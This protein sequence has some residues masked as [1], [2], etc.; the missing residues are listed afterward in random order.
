MLILGLTGGIAMG[1]SHVARLFRGHGV[2]LFDSDAAVHALYAPGGR[3]AR[4]VGPA[5]PGSADESGG[6]DRG[7]L[8]ALVIG[9]Q[10]KLRVLERIVHGLVREEQVAF[11]RLACAQGRL[12]VVLDVPLLLET[13]LQRRVDRV[14]VVSSPALLQRDRALCRP[15]MTPARLEAIRAQQMPDGIKRRH[16]DFVIPGGRDRGASAAAVRR[17]LGCLTGERGTAWPG[18]WLQGRSPAAEWEGKKR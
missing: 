12:L 2:P 13:G 10:G 18:R 6:I 16:A 15:G 9:D 17:L 1:K 14:A 11:L 5:F 7:R 4:V 8:A 3:A